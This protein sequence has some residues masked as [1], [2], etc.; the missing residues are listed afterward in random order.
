MRDEKLKRAGADQHNLGNHTIHEELAQFQT[1]TFLIRYCEED[2]EINDVALFRA[3]I[4]VQ[5]GYL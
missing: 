3:E 4:D 2:V 1:K 5:P